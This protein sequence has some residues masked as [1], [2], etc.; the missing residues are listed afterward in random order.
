M[1]PFPQPARRLIRFCRG[2]S[3]IELLAVVTIMGILALLVVPRFATQSVNAK[4][5]GCAVNKGNIEVQCQ[6]WLRQ[7]NAAPTSTLSD[8]GANRNYFPEGLPTCP[9]DGS[10]YTMNTTT[11]RVNGHAH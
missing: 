2:M 10:A 9:V 1:R 5:Q 8:I 3:L 7:K 11:L 4:K 6:L